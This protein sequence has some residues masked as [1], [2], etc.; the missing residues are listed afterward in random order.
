MALS[1]NSGSVPS[2]SH[3]S[4]TF[5]ILLGF[6]EVGFQFSALGWPGSR[7]N[8]V[9]FLGMC[10][11]FDVDPSVH[12]FMFGRGPSQKSPVLKH[13]DKYGH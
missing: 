4:V 7:F 3:V 2:N 9:F 13:R 5:S 12:F 8:P 1:T 10:I 11:Q 6:G